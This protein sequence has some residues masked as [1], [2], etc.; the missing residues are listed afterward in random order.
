MDTHAN[1]GREKACKNCQ[2]LFFYDVGR[3][4][5]RLYCNNKC[6]TQYQARAWTERKKDLPSCSVDGCSMPAVRKK[7]GLCETH[8]YRKRR[9]GTTSKYVRTK[10][11]TAAGYVRVPNKLHPL[12]NKD[13]WIYVH[14]SVVY[15][16]H[17]GVCP[18]CF[19]CGKSLVWSSAVVDHIN[20]VK[21]D[22]SPE[23]L[24]VV[25]N[26]CNRARG[27][28]L[29]FIIGLREESMEMFLHSLKLMRN[30]TVEI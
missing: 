3:G 21:N 25:C 4:K 28:M 27:A 23:N 5:D 1:S 7:H 2:C 24:K 11:V 30:G 13:G 8:F 22:N 29:P 12:A 19:W 14:R 16:S 10:Y 6:R 18:N 26:R 17:Q 9:N 15:E 20:E